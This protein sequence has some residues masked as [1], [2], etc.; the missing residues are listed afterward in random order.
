MVTTKTYRL[1]AFA[2]ALLIGATACGTPSGGPG[3]GSTAPSGSPG[4]TVPSSSQVSTSGSTPIRYDTSA[5]AP[6]VLISVVDATVAGVQG[7]GTTVLYGDGTLL[8][9][10]ESGGWT[11]S[12][13]APGVI[14]RILARAAAAGL[15][16]DRDPGEPGISDQGWTVVSVTADGRTHDYRI[17]APGYENGLTTAELAV[18]RDLADFQRAVGGLA[19]ADLVEAPAPY[20]VERLRVMVGAGGPLDDQPVKR[21]WPASI[22]LRD[23]FGD[24][25]CAVLTG[26]QAEAVAALVGPD[27]GQQAGPVLVNTGQKLPAVVQVRAYPLLPHD[28]GCAERQQSQELPAPWP[29]DDRRPADAWSTWIAHQVVTEAG[30][31]QRLGGEILTPTSLTWFRL[32]SSA[33][34]V[35]G[36]TVIDVVGRRSH[37]RTA[38]G[39]TEFA[40]RF[41]PA[42]GEILKVSSR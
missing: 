24:T 11:R 38:S 3:I 39:M 41:N 22:P 19:G 10:N 7:V 9:P 16:Q 5:T 4:S 31:Q 40:I 32:S 35:D 36:T 12:K 21:D 18:R 37:G 15:L 2:A 30:A 6:V 34:T 33:V 29:G 20:R 28:S 17:Y 25:G 14:D 13:V 26:Q 8:R 42:T 1:L 27:D 23:T